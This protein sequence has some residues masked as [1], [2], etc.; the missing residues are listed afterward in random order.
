M[1]QVMCGEEGGAEEGK[2]KYS[3]QRHCNAVKARGQLCSSSRRRP[4]VS[5]SYHLTRVLFEDRPHR[6]SACRVD[7][8][9]L[10]TLIVL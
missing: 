4:A 10:K 1:L 8:L 2:N 5:C 6:H 7:V 3:S 9:C